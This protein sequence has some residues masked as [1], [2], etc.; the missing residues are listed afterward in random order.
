[1]LLR[2]QVA[3]YALVYS[4]MRVLPAHPIGFALL[5]AKPSPCCF[6]S[7]EIDTAQRNRL[8]VVCYSA[9]LPSP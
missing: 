2:T 4:G 9:V 6:D 5:S 8:E 1:M 7:H 3:S